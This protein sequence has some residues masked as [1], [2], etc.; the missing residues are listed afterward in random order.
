[1]GR[2]VYEGHETT[3]EQ[4]LRV[5]SDI[6]SDWLVLK[7]EINVESANEFTHYL[8]CQREDDVVSAFVVL[9][10]YDADANGRPITLYKWLSESEGPFAYGA[11]RELI[12]MLTPI[13][14]S[15]EMW[16]FQFGRECAQ[17]WRGKCAGVRHPVTEQTH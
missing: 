12:A 4:A 8:A 1:M 11:S 6:R 2:D 5:K 14:D 17:R 10:E 13:D 7:H 16:K 15:M 9:V 3:R